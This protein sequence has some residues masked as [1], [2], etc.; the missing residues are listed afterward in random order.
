[1]FRTAEKSSNGCRFQLERTSQLVIAEALAAENEQL[2]LPG[3]D[4]SQHRA[5][6]LLVLPG[7]PDFLWAWLRGWRV[8]D[9]SQQAF[10]LRTPGLAAQLVQ[11]G[12]YGDPIEPGLGVFT[13]R[14]R[15]PRPFQKNLNREL[16]GSCR[17][18][19]NA[20]NHTGDSAILSMKD[21]LDI[22]PAN[23]G[24]YLSNCFMRCIHTS[25]TLF[26]ASL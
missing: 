6:V 10:A 17:V 20:R 13:L 8:S 18:P 12:S 5:N 14:L 24:A 9:E 16:L 11:A 25:I 22:Q 19:Q 15:I 2:S 3:L 23:V 7:G 1:M 26:A 4:R 21:R